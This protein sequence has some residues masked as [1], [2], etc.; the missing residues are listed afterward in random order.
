MTVPDEQGHPEPPLAGDE[1]ATLLS[2]L[3]RHPRR[4]AQAPGLRRGPLVLPVDRTAG[5]GAGQ[6]RYVPGM[7]EQITPRQFHEADVVTWMGRD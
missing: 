7:T 2:S 6:P 4:A 5:T 1:T 3:D